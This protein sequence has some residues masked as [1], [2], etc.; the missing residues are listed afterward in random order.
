MKISFFSSNRYMGPEAYADKRWPTPPSRYSSDT[1]RQSLETALELAGLADDLGYDWVS[2]SEHHYTALLQTPNANLYAAALCSVVK[3]ARIALLGPL[4]SLAQPVRV[5]EEI[6]QLDQLSN[7]RLIVLPL[8]G[9][10]NE[11]L[12]YGVN[13]DE[14]RAITEEATLLILRA[15]RDREPFGWQG[16]Y[17]QH[18]T[19]AVWPR[20]MQT[21][22]PFYNSGNSKDSA[23]FAAANRLGFA[24]SFF[25]PHVTAQMTA[26]Y[27]TE[28]ER[29]GWTPTPDQMLYRCY[30]AVGEDDAEAE[31]LREKYFQRAS[32]QG[33]FAG[34]GAALAMPKQAEAGFGLGELRFCGTPD[35]VV[36][37]ICTFYEQ[38]GIGVIDIGFGSVGLTAGETKKSMTLFAQEV[39][40]RI[41][42]LGVSVE[43]TARA[44]ARVPVMADVQ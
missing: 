5:A 1:G 14:T 24:A 23:S 10:G 36:E 12:S 9:T 20:C 19:V 34:R 16:R 35:R 30:G 31:T 8:R 11:F 27:R 42:S 17:F 22:V 26:F 6:A 7:G 28:C 43:P 39:L 32:I 2:C 25:P 29:H 33:L 21:P 4:V 13:P 15:L 37:Q 38:T 41:R 40:P 3:R 44:A 18:R